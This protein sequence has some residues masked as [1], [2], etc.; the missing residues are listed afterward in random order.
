VGT[1][2]DLFQVSVLH[3]IVHLLIGRAGLVAARAAR[4]ARVCLIVGGSSIWCCGPR[5][6]L[7][8]GRNR[9]LVGKKL[10]VREPSLVPNVH[11]SAVS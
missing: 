3:N 10:Q 9:K 8:K 6:L 5:R 4:T 2:L 1:L 11:C 7:N